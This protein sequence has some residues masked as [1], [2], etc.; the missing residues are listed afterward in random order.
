MSR[1]FRRNES[2]ET[3]PRKVPQ[4]RC[5]ACDGAAFVRSPNVAAFVHERGL[6]IYDRD[7]VPADAKHV[8]DL[9]RPCPNRTDSF[10]V[11]FYNRT[12]VAR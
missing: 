1:G 12:E 11:E 10:A 6:G 4:H 2:A 7:L 3:P 5:S 9:M 8:V